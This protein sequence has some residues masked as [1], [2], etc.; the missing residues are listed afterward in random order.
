MAEVFHIITPKGKKVPILL[1]IPHVGMAF[2]E[3]LEDQYVAELAQKPDDTD[4]YLDQLYDFA[5]SLGIT[6]IHAKYSRWVIDLNR[7]PDSVALYDDGRIITALTPITDFLGN[8][9]YRK[10]EFEPDSQEVARRRLM[11]RAYG[12]VG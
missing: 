8:P 9:I 6:T 5:A 12:P 2:P 3:E 4:F 10:K 7:N 1:S 11:R